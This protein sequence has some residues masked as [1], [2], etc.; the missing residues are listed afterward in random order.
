M[1]VRLIRHTAGESWEYSVREHGSVLAASNGD[2]HYSTI[3]EALKAALLDA[4]E[5]IRS[6]SEKGPQS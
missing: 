6:R 2:D 5:S 4:Q 3:A 1:E